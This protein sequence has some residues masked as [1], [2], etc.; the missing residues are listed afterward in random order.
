MTETPTRVG[1]PGDSITRRNR[2]YVRARCQ[3]VA[4]LRTRGS[5]RTVRCRGVSVLGFDPIPA[6]DRICMRH[7]PARVLVPELSG[8]FEH[9]M[10]WRATLPRRVFGGDEREAPVN[11]R[12]DARTLR[13][14]RR[15][16]PQA[17]AQ[18]GCRVSTPFPCAQARTYRRAPPFPRSFSLPMMRGWR[19]GTGHLI[20]GWLRL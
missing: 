10:N 13:F 7:C 6:W 2:V 1:Y 5:S 18:T 8:E 17:I 19:A 11:R 3:P 4:P 16:A 14:A 15:M 20:P 12:D 9:A